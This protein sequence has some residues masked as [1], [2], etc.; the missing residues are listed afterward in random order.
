ML[1]IYFGPQIEVRYAVLSCLVWK[2]GKK[3]LPI[4]FAHSIKTQ[5]NLLND[6][7]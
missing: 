2:K 3:N 7:N 6:F 1:K 4:R 5:N